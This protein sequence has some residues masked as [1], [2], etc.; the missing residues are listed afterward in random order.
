M[1]A[2]VSAA[3]REMAQAVVAQWREEKVIQP[4]NQ[5]YVEE[6]R[7]SDG[8]HFSTFLTYD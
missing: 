8:K 6:L 2:D 1:C 7:G 3:A 5:D 4:G